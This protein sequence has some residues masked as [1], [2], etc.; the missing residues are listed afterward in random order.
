M[1]KFKVWDVIS[2]AWTEIGLEPED[3]PKYA[4]EIYTEC[5]DWN[6]VNS[7]ITRDV[8]GS[9]AIDTFLIFPCMLWVIMPDWGYD[10][11]YLKNRMYKWYSKPTWLHF[12][13]PI[14][15]LGYPIALLLSMPIRIKLKKA[16]KQCASNT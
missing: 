4:K 16:F 9:F 3:Y 10:T 7:I 11:E 8:C 13:N 2:Y 15:I 6:R 5:L 14:R 1:E 12:V